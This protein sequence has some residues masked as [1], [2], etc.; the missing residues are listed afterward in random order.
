MINY[1]ND[2]IQLQQ[3]VALKKQLEA[4]LND[5]RNQRKVFDKKVIELRVEHRSEQEDVEKL[6]GRSLANYFYQLFGKLDEKLSE[7]RR[8]AS[9]AKVKLDAAERELA[10]VDCEIEEIQSQLQELYGC[11]QD[12][13]AALEAKR[14][15]VKSSGTPTAAQ[16]LELEERIAF[17]ESQKKEIREAISAGY[18]ALGT[19][20]SVLSEL[21]DADGWN[22][23]DMLGGGGIITHMAK[24]S[25]LDEAQEKVEQL[26][27]KLRRFKTELADIDI[28]ADMQVSIDGFLRFA[29][30][31]FDGLF[32]DWAVGD[33]ISESL[34][35]VQRVKGQISSALSKLESMEENANREIQSLNAKIE[36]LIVNG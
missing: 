4:K 33:K 30:Y 9:A 3:K 24:H 27:G 20:D 17:L 35:S 5:L 12:Y 11:E 2:L 26:Q 19:A 18:S 31:F 29:D 22:T 28:H 8:E 21:E 6:E 15:V 13:A 1:D 10:A 32:A 34:S 23:W 14:N 36:E 7:E 25:H 16:I